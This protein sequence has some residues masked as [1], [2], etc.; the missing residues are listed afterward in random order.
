MKEHQKRRA[1]LIEQFK[2]GKL[3]VLLATGILN[4]GF[5]APN[6][7]YLILAGGGKAE[8]LQTQRIGRGMRAADGKESVIVIDFMDRGHYL[9]KHS[10]ARLNAYQ[11]EPAF[12]VTCL[13]VEE[14]E[15][16][17]A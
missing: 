5:D 16:M 13:T 8:H 11:A 9:S 6:V 12:N 4:E 17:F 1:R 15:A 3:D 14:L 2:A 7:R 10:K